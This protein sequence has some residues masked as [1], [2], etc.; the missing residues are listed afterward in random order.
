MILVRVGQDHAVQMVNAQNFQC[1]GN[2]APA[3]GR[4]GV[5]HKDLLAQRQQMAVRFAD[6]DGGQGDFRRGK[7]TSGEKKHTT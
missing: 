2:H 3:F 6:V 5:D 7:G 4:A 1:A